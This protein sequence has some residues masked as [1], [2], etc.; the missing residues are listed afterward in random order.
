MLV[1]ELSSKLSP[2]ASPAA[3]NLQ[4][5][6]VVLTTSKLKRAIVCSP[7]RIGQPHSY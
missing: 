4:T 1:F 7:M 6:P 5:H 2:Q 3:R